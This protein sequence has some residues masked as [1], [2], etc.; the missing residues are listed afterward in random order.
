MP[1]IRLAA[2][3]V[4]LVLV[5]DMKYM[6]TDA[7]ITSIPMKISN[8]NNVKHLIRCKEIKNVSSPLTSLELHFKIY[9]FMMKRESLS[10]WFLKIN[11]TM[12]WETK[13]NVCED[14]QEN[15]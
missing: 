11:M 10:S 3:T 2:E 14:I 4:C 6:H 9:M 12:G 15:I 5:N 7:T 13:F 1:H 8:D